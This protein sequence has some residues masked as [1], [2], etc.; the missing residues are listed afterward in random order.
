[1]R[2]SQYVPPIIFSLVDD[3]RKNKVKYFTF[4]KYNNL[5]IIYEK[6]KDRDAKDN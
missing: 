2:Q 4:N 6:Y 5:N 1:M 3:I